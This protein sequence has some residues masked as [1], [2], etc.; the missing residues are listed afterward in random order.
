MRWLWA[1]ILLAVAA[2]ADGIPVAYLAAPPVIDGRL[3]PALK[4]LPRL[5]FPV[6]EAS[7]TLP[8]NWAPQYRI[9]YGADFLYL[10]IEVPDD[11][12][13]TRDRAYQNGDGYILVLTEPRSDGAPSEVFSV[14]G[15]TASAQPLADWQAK[16]RWYHNKDL[17]FER[18]R[19]AQ[20]AT[21]SENGHTGIELLLPWTAVAQHPWLGPIGFNLSYVKAEGE[22]AHSDFFVTADDRIQSEQSPRQSV[23]LAFAPPSGEVPALFVAL[24]A[25]HV[26]HGT[27]ATAR[28]AAYMPTSKIL[29]VSSGVSDSAE[30]TVAVSVRDR[31]APAGLSVQSVALPTEGLVPGDYTI[32]WGGSL[33]G[34]ASAPLTI[35]PVFDAKD[36]QRRL[37]SLKGRSGT[38][39]TL[40]FRAQ[41][42]ETTRASLP[43]ADTATGLRKM[44]AETVSLLADAER[45]R[46]RLTTQTGLI[47]RAYRSAVDGSLQPYTVRIPAHFERGK[48]YP[49][50][51][52]LH[53]SGQDDTSAI[54]EDQFPADAIVLAPN[55]RG[56]SNGYIQDH[57]Q[58]DIREAVADVAANYPVDPQRVVIAGFSMG[59]YGTYHTFASA[60]GQ[61][62]AAAIFSGDPSLGPKWFGA[63]APDYLAD[64]NAF[65][66]AE[67]FVFHGGK[68]R[69]CPIETTRAMIAKLE[70]AGAHVTFDYDPDRGHEAPSAK[71]IAAYHAWLKHVLR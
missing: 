66:G 16:F 2:Q 33:A 55:G 58:D 45:G 49:L 24:A 27:A 39:T 64:A 50:I 70:A 15:F 35:L 46:D 8:A 71:T 11:H 3:D 69:N 29:S 23:P 51:V 54:S 60:R 43:P 56:T 10:Y 19:T 57:A 67:I 25:G 63:G 47:R 18:L 37:A 6:R 42:I 44:I 28:I 68:D 21:L 40:Q 31:S 17:T 22:A 62:R 41:Q 5:D 26:D 14:L 36:V 12:L 30:Q 52:F 13:I 61:Y 32:G 53:G 9:G 7:A 34:S 65:R 59:G 38:V 20:T 1:A 4:T 48:K